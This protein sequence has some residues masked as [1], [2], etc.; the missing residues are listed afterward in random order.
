[1]REEDLTLIPGTIF[2]NKKTKTTVVIKEV[3]AM[4]VIYTFGSFSKRDRRQRVMGLD[5]FRRSM[6]K[7]DWAM[8]MEGSDEKIKP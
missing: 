3:K 8:E 4:V 2:V 1:M 6:L 5:S 7:D